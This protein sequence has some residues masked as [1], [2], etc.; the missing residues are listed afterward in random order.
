MKCPKCNRKI[1]ITYEP[2]VVGCR[3]RDYIYCPYPD[4]DWVDD[5]Y[6]L[7]VEYHCMK[8][9]NDNEAITS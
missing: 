2:Q 1:I 7:E 3:S 5:D 9:E 4:C 6:S 8:G